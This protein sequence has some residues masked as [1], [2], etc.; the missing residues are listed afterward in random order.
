[1]AARG[2]RPALGRVSVHGALTLEPTRAEADRGSAQRAVLT[3]RL[4]KHAGEIRFLGVEQTRTYNNAGSLGPSTLVN[5]GSLM[6][7]LIPVT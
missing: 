3:L 6:T 4:S 2:G 5:L 1:M 7:V